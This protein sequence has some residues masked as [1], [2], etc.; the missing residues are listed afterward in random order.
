[1]F[2]TIK[3]IYHEQIKNKNIDSFVCYRGGVINQEEF[4]YY[5]N[6]IGAYIQNLGF[7]SAS[8]KKDIPI[9]KDYTS[10]IYFTIKVDH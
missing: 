2:D 8:L 9:T 6:N 10:N 1:M 5:Q 3:E 7:L 4:L